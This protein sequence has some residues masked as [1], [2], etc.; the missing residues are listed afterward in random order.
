[1]SAA[2]RTKKMMVENLKELCQTIPLKKVTVKKIIEKCEI[3]RG[4]FYYHFP[5]KQALI[6]Y[7]YHVDVTV[8]L[9]KKIAEGVEN[10]NNLTL[11]SLQFMREYPE[12]YRQA[13]KITGP[14]DM[15]SY[16]ENEVKENWRIIAR[17]YIKYYKKDADPD[18]K[19]LYY[20]SEYFAAGAVAMLKNWI[21]NGMAES[22]EEIAML[23]DLASDNGM[24]KAL[25]YI[26]DLC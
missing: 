4:T 9:R 17:M 6:N 15:L 8:P 25:E 7:T 18:Y 11:S 19:K 14:N 13:L 20:I 24:G 21:V 3:N 2:D 26:A 10:W 16:I 23:L 22:P 1:M 5:D 12:F